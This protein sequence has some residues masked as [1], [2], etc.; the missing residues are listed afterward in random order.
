MNQRFV[1]MCLLSNF[2]CFVVVVVV[3][4]VCT[5]FFCFILCLL[6]EQLVGRVYVF[7]YV[8]GQDWGSN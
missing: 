5:F 7:P 1:G 2:M 4:C 8:G 6:H 3:V